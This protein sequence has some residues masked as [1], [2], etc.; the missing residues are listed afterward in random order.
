MNLSNNHQ[1]FVIK[2]DKNKE[3]VQFDKI[4]KRIACLVKENEL[5]FIDPIK[6][7]Q[8]A[9][10]GIYNGIT[11]TELDL[12][13]SKISASMSTTHPLYSVLG[14]RILI[15]NLH[16]NTFD[17]FSEKVK[18][19]NDNLTLLNQEYYQWIM[20]IRKTLDEYIKYDRD[21]DL[22]FFGFKTLE[23]AYL[24]RIGDKIVERPQDMF[25]RVASF[26]NMGDLESTLK[27]YDL[28]SQGY[29]THASP[30]LFNSGIKRSQ[31]SSCFLLGTEDSMDGITDTW[32]S[33][34]SISK[35]GGGI[36]IHISNIRASGSLIRGTNGPS[37]GI[38]P[39][40]R[41]YNEIA[42]YVN[43]CFVGTTKIYTEKGLVPIENLKVGDK[44]FTKDG[45][46]KHI[47]KI[48]QDKYSGNAINIK[49]KHNFD[50]DITVTPEHPFLVI[51][52][53]KKKTNYKVF[54]NRI[55]K[56]LVEKEW[57][58]AK[59][60]T[61]DDLIT[62]PIPKYEKD[63]RLYDESDCY[64]YGVMLGDGHMCKD[65]NEEGIT[66]GHK[67]E[68]VIEFV[69]NYLDLNLIKY[70][71]NETESV[72]NIRW[73]VSSKFKFTRNQLYDNN[74]IKKC[75]DIMLNLPLKKA[76]SIIK[77]LM[78]TEGC[79]GNELTLELTSLQVLES[80]KYILLRMGV[81]SSGY[82]RNRVGNVSTY[83]N[84]TTRLP[85]WVLRIPKVESIAQ[86]LE[87]EPGKYKKFFSYGDFLYTRFESIEP[88]TIDTVVYDLEIDSNHNYLTEIGLVHNGG[89]RKGSI[90]MYL[91][92]HHADIF[93]FL[94]LRKNFGA[95]TERARDLFLALWVSDLF[96]KQV[97]K[98]SDWYLMCP[99]ES[100]G[101]CDVYGV[102][103]EELY[104][105]YV[106][107]NK[108]KKKI[109]ARELW[110]KILE[111][112]IETGTPYM[113]YKDSINKKSNQKNIGTIRSSN[114]CAE[115]VQY[116]DSKQHAVCNLASIAISKCI[117]KKKFDKK[118]L[119]YSKPNCKY[120]KWVVAKLKKEEIEYIKIDFNE[121]LRN[122][123]K[124][125]LGD[126]KLTFPQVYYGTNH[127]G[128]YEETVKYVAPEYDFEKLHQVAYQ[129][130]FN[131][132][133][134]IDVNF[135]PT[136]EGKYS[137]M[138]HRPIGLGIQG[139][140][141]TLCQLKIAYDTDEAIK[142]NSDMMETI[143]HGALQ[144]SCDLAKSRYQSMRELIVWHK[145]NPGILPKY[146]DKN[147]ILKWDVLNKLYHETKPC[148]F[149]LELP[150]D[151]TCGSYSTF[152]GSP[153]SKGILQFDMWGHSPDRYDWNKLKQN[154][155]K[156]GTRNSLLTA[157]MP[158]AS[159]SQIL[160]NVESFEAYTNNIYNRRTLAG[161]FVVGNKYMISDLHEIGIWN[162]ELKNKI[163]G[164]NGSLSG[165]KEIPTIYRNLYKNIWE[166]KQIWSVKSAL[167]RAPFVDQTQSMNIYMATPNNNRL[168]S[169]HFYG[170]K[171][172]LKTGIYYLRSKPSKS[173][174]KF[175]VRPQKLDTQEEDECIMCSS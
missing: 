147:L 18:L 127:I 60:I 4:T 165:I 85:T 22:D 122:E 39:M 20:K 105:K 73:I 99:D 16:K 98:N 97:Q 117:K 164:N 143:Y 61:S 3:P 47:K 76:K 118:F 132:N 27:T 77:G 137:N 91:E 121:K 53:Q 90:A 75:D 43:Q 108:Y 173:A 69:K 100:P 150:C 46:M 10:A 88:T 154:I 113:L 131:L 119:V 171:K 103:Y 146:Y 34:S 25:M 170:W 116:S 19:L 52:N 28:M 157:L 70:W 152:K 120:C 169:S 144:A 93:P 65:R 79:I 142:F 115:I 15:S 140:I 13:S 59:N 11:T 36:G 9:V 23:R 63:F 6:V 92:P 38:I 175:T 153:F 49:S 128:G 160:G 162:K 104:W 57:V 29:Y 5:E 51:K 68:K 40:C 159:T 67:K 161:D 1:M 41:V 172:G 138:L 141:D 163:I 136:P 151:S 72:V 96:M 126:K 42:R 54:E 12:L 81:L 167:A 124:T 112:Q 33:V 37:S 35:W 111:S 14:A 95:E 102:K 107:E 156:Y 129:A 66:L 149:E 133:K 135:Y 58:E 45:T 145:T 17:T 26:I 78:D 168:S 62:I 166:I 21:F 125:H 50:W 89:K 94:D 48:Y 82:S 158:T 32:K 24:M 7:A 155:I 114:L 139:V 110:D 31:C 134:V 174:I 109:K 80:I 106:S 101:L 83:K 123:L 8:Q 84:I 2:R 44:V 55:K 148:I 56:N 86:L 87:I 74:K 71:V 130:T 64:F 30:T